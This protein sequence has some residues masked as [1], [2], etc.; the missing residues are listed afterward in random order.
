MRPSVLVVGL[1]LGCGDNR[2]VQLTSTDAGG[3]RSPIDAGT[4]DAALD[5][6]IDAATVDNCPHRTAPPGVPQEEIPLG[7]TIVGTV[8]ISTQADVE[9][10]AGIR[11]VTGDVIF[12]NGFFL[13]EVT[14]PD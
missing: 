1:F 3:D 7:A 11:Y 9:A 6:A 5:A 4:V 12:D 2:A 14:L 10:L 8:H 13:P